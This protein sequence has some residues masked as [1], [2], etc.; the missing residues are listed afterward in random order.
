MGILSFRIEVL[1]PQ[2]HEQIYV[3]SMSSMKKKK[4]FS[5]DR[6]EKY[7]F[8][9]VET[10]PCPMPRTGAKQQLHSWQ[11][12]N[13]NNFFCY[14]S[15][16]QHNKLCQCYNV[17]AFFFFFQS[18]EKCFH[19]SGQFK[20]KPGLRKIL[21]RQKETLHLWHRNFAVD[22]FLTG[23][24]KIKFF[25]YHYCF[26]LLELSLQCKSDTALNAEG[27]ATLTE[28]EPDG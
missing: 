6:S 24:T 3:S 9:T 12:Y 27:L 15:S 21:T 28:L 16:M 26:F 25:L 5:L 23:Q 14:F 7:I 4:E 22:L 13:A 20:Q 8:P 18:G 17:L 11:Q 19:F 10:A 2:A 1:E